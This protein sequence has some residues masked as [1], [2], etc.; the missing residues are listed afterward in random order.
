MAHHRLMSRL[1]VLAIGLGGCTAPSDPMALV[2][3]SVQATI[4]AD[5]AREQA[6]ASEKAAE[7]GKVSEAGGAIPQLAPFDQTQS[8][9][10]TTAGKQSLAVAASDARAGGKSNIQEILARARAAPLNP[11]LRSAS[12]EGGPF[13]PA[14]PDGNGD[15]PVQRTTGAPA[16]S[17]TP[18]TAI[19]PPP[20]QLLAVPRASGTQKM[21]IEPGLRITFASGAKTLSTFEQTKLAAA[22][23]NARLTPGGRVTLSLGPASSNSGFERLTLARR[24]GE[25]IATLLPQGLDIVQEYKPELPPD[26]V[27]ITFGT[28]SVTELVPQ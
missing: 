22:V 6:A 17:I 23:A 27:W 24:R 13:V 10:A 3:P 20:T 1:S 28:R 5:H 4:A 26:A 2:P 14:L 12:A 7:Q 19:A 8:A 15:D 16:T 9:G 25:A 11:P 18:G 21:P